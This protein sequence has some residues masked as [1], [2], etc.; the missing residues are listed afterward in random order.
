MAEH[1]EP[2][3]DGKRSADKPPIPRAPTVPTLNA[4]KGR[5]DCMRDQNLPGSGFPTNKQESRDP[6]ETTTPS[7][8]PNLSQPLAISK[9]SEQASS[10]TVD[11]GQNAKRRKTEGSAD[12]SVPHIGPHA[13]P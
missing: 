3:F 9:V 7:V 8:T 4:A 13:H 5:R 11:R 6:A 10:R 12:P 2:G 1:D